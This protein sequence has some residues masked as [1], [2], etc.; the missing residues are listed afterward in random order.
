LT[1]AVSCLSIGV[2]LVGCN[3]QTRWTYPFHHEH[4]YRSSRI[5]DLSIAVTPFEERRPLKNSMAGIFIAMIPLVPY[6]TS[7]L[8]RPEAAANYEF[9]MAED[10]AKAA[11]ESLRVSKLFKKTFFS[12]GADLDEADYILRGRTDSTTYKQTMT[13]YGL[14]LPGD[15]LWLL[16]FPVGTNQ[17]ELKITVWLEDHA[18]KE[19]WSYSFEDSIKRTMIYYRMSSDNVLGTFPKLMENAMNGALRDLLPLLEQLE[20]E[21]QSSE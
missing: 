21:A 13:F 6:G 15:L 7:T 19:R 1:A 17:A 18:G 8:N 10:L 14:S 20:A 4:L 9:D 12:Y 3:I 16:G 5:Y 11:H 2:V